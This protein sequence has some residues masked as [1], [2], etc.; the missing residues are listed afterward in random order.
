MVPDSGLQQVRYYAEWKKNAK[1]EDSAVLLSP[2]LKFFLLL[3][4]ELEENVVATHVLHRSGELIND[5]G[6]SNSPFPF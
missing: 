6:E 4:R 5:E 1:S 3:F 2:T